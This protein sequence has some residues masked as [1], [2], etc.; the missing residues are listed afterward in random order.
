VVDL[1]ARLRQR[2]AERAAQQRTRQRYAS[3]GRCGVQMQL[4]DSQPLCF[5]SNDYLGLAGHPV[6]EAAAIAALQR[7]GT[8]AGA[9]H[10]ISGHHRIHAELEE[11]LAEFTGRSRA[12]LFGSGYA[13]NMGTINALLER[14]D[15]LLQDS[16]NHAS[17][18]DGGQLC[19][20]TAKRYRH[21]DVESAARQLNSHQSAAGA[22]L[23][24]TD[25]VFSMDGD[26]APL[27]ELATL[28]GQRRAT[29]MV[30]DAHGF[31][32]LGPTG[33]GLVEELGLDCQQ[34]PVLVGT[35]GKS[36][37]SYGAFV[38]GSETLIDALMQFSRSYIYTTAQPPAIAAASLAALTLVRD[39]SWRRDHL[40][41][42]IEYFRDCAEQL[43]LPLMASQTAIQPLLVG[44]EAEL[45][46][47]DAQLR[48]RGLWVGAIRP[49]T[50]AVGSARLRITL[51]A[52]HSRSDLDR[53]LEALAELC[54]PERLAGG[55]G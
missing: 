15:L 19:K 44:A 1:D 31:G 25:G 22:T 24:A 39:E 14:G 17:L 52:A 23:V 29:L 12:L 36:F 7:Y 48:S 49:P 5:A 30:D 10:L 37:G 20:A 3:G 27:T 42:L 32:L 35:L 16:L 11:A 55:H 43:G 33:G 8:G 18:I 51:T 2:L 34:V 46:A 47:I 45:M 21:A 54:H 53:L 4:A 6:V 41:Q 28:C 9:S 50:V 13:A 38:A 40:N 26:C